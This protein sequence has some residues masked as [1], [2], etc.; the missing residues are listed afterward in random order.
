MPIWNSYFLKGSKS[1][2]LHFKN[3]S[4]QLYVIEKKDL[5]ELWFYIAILEV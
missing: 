1:I 2:V 5:K 4:F 3:L